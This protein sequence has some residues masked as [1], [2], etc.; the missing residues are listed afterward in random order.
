MSYRIRH[1]FIAFVVTALTV[2]AQ[3]S[4]ILD[5]M[6]AARNFR[7]ELA[8][9]VASNTKTPAEAINLLRITGRD[10]LLVTKD[11]DVDL[12]YDTL[13]I[14]YR[15]LTLECPDAAEFFFAAAEQNFSQAASRTPRSQAKERAQYLLHLARIRCHF[16]NN[17]RQAIEDIDE[18]L[19]L[20]PNDK[21]LHEA[22]AMIVRGQ[23]EYYKDTP[24]N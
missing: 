14:G 15:L 17:I 2:S 20:Q 21:S 13:D 16:L 4:A 7:Q 9:A 18:A 10:S 3:Q 11:P 1:Y 23:T 8:L 22:R 12:A 6:L 19:S 5:A 24:R